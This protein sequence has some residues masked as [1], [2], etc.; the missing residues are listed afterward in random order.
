MRVFC[1]SETN[2]WQWNR[3]K[4][5]F[6]ESFRWEIVRKSQIIRHS[7]RADKIPNGFLNGY[8]QLRKPEKFAKNSSCFNFEYIL[9]TSFGLQCIEYNNN[10]DWKLLK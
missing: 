10:T 9:M 5:D 2:L 4:N 1:F 7:S 3:F 8:D 6:Q